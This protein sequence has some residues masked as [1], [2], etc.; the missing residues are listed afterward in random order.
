MKIERICQN[1]YCNKHFFAKQADV[2]RGWA[3]YCSKSCKAVHQELKRKKDR[4]NVSN[5]PINISSKKKKKNIHAHLFS[6]K[7][8]TEHLYRKQLYE[9]NNDDYEKALKL[10][11]LQE[12]TN[13]M[14]KSV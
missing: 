5:N 10:P 14:I 7:E 4:M 13:F 1:V 11:S 8:L 12:A 3:L 9:W 6:R 2:N